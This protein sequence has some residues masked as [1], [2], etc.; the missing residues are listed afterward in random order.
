MIQSVKT[1]Y[2][3]FD[4]QAGNLIVLTTTTFKSIL[5]LIIYIKQKS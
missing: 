5:P 1:R 2:F 3:L 4:N